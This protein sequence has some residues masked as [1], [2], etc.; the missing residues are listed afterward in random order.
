MARI[1]V[2]AGT[3]GAGKSSILGRN[4]EDLNATYLNPDLLA[5]SHT[6]QDPSISAE[7]ANSR[8]WFEMVEL[9]QRSIDNDLD[10]AFETTLGGSTITNLLL[11]ASQSGTDIRV[12]YV[13][14]ATPDLHIERV[15]IRVGRGGHHVPEERIR[16]RFVSGPLNLIRLMPSLRELWVFDNS[17]STPTGDAP[18]EPR[19]YLHMSSGSI[20]SSIGIEAANEWAHPILLAAEGS[21]S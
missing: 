8:A 18:A 11:E 6:S 20:V 19:L 10:F 12:A 15:A 3:N 21:V 2:L 13:G 5:K 7:E 16:E 4:I 17:Q 14:L 9:L 1:Q